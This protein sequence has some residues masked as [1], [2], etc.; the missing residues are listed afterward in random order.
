[1]NRRDLLISVALGA[2]ASAM[3]SFASAPRLRPWT[4]PAGDN[5]AKY[6]GSDV[7]CENG[8]YAFTIAGVD[9]NGWPKLRNAAG[10]DVTSQFTGHMF[11]FRCA[12]GGITTQKAGW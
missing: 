8:H 3:P 12:C 6:V 5:A 4:I 7:Y 9:G 2:A 11:P 10:E 1:M